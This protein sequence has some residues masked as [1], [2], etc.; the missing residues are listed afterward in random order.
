[1]PNL[2]WRKSRMPG[3][4]AQRYE[5]VGVVVSFMAERKFVNIRHETIEGFMNAMT[6][7]FEVKDTTLLHGI[8]EGDSI[9]FRFTVADGIDALEK[10]E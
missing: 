4:T 6:M 1:M 8:E 5:A 7:P 9:T 2:W 10:I 3:K